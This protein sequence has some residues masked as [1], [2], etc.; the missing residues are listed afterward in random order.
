MTWLQYLRW[1]N[2]LRGKWAATSECSG[3]A[4]SSS[5]WVPRWARHIATLPSTAA[6]ITTAV[7]WASTADAPCSRSD[8]A[9]IDVQFAKAAAAASTCRRPVGR[10][11]FHRSCQ[12]RTSSAK[13]TVGQDL[14]P[15]LQEARRSASGL[16]RNSFV[17]ARAVR[18]SARRTAS[19]ASWYQ[20]RGSSGTC[21]R[22]S[23]DL[24]EA[25][26]RWRRWRL[27]APGFLVWA[28]RSSSEP[29]DR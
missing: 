4:T 16:A 9:R 7:R 21:F 6:T 14:S 28:G 17:N 20:P 5:G 22:S 11:V 23:V 13:V 24:T 18:S 29:Q 2:Y 8:C 26:C 3:A 1:I 12:H 25:V 27:V 15:H 19:A 10:Q